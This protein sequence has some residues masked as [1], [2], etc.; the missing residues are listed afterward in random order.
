MNVET[1]P[2]RTKDGALT[3][4]DHSLVV[5]LMDGRDQSVN[6]VIKI[7]VKKKIIVMKACMKF[8]DTIQLKFIK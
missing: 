2:V 4:R 6:K 7:Y 1:T 8:I 5:V 3:V